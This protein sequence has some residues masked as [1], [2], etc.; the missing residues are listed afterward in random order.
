MTVINGPEKSATGIRKTPALPC[1]SSTQLKQDA[2]AGSVVCK[3]REGGGRG[4]L[5]AATTSSLFVVVKQRTNRRSFSA[6]TGA[7]SRL[8]KPGGPASG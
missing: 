8:F 5:P 4:E 6:P 3:L 2:G 7:G 1:M